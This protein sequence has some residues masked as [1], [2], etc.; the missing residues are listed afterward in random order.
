MLW[1]L[2]FWFF[3]LLV[4]ATTVGR[5]AIYFIKPGTVSVYEILESLPGLA[6]AVA[7]YGFAFGISIGSHLLWVVV[8]CIV[9]V[10]YFISMRSK[11]TRHAVQKLG[12]RKVI[13]IVGGTFL[14]TLP[15]YVALVMY[16]S[17][18]P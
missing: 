6:C 11:K 1:K 18:M 3:A 8:A 4:A 16:A 7:L 17:Q 14:A 12:A 5:S 15:A 13:V 9:P 2:Y 10:T